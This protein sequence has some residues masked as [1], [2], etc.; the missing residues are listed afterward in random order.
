MTFEDTGKK[1]DEINVDISYRII[2][3]FSKGLYA[4][5][6]KA[7]E[8]L[9]S[10]SYDAFADKVAVYVPSDKA[11]PD[12]VMWVCDNGEALNLNGLK[13]LWRIGESNKRAIDYTDK[14][15]VPIGKFGIGKL[16]TYVLSRKLTHI[17]KKDGKYLAVTMDYGR[18]KLV[19]QNEQLILDA[20]EL[21]EEEA[22]GVL[23]QLT[24]VQGV[25]L[26]NF[27]LF[28]KDAEESWTFALMSDLTPKAN[29]LKNGRLEWVLSTAL[30]LSPA[31]N[32]FFNGHTIDSS[33]LKNKPIKTWIIGRDDQMITKFKEYEAGSDAEKPC[34]NLPNLNGVTGSIELYEESLLKG[35]SEDISRSNG[36]FLMIRGRLVNLDDP[37]LG[38]PA[39]SHGVF[40]RSR[41]VVHADGLDDYLS[42]TRESIQESKA[43]SDLRQYIQRKFEEV[44]AFYFERLEDKDRTQN[45][46]YKVSQTSTTMSRRPLLVVARKFFDEEISTPYLI[47]I[48]N[49]LTKPDQDNLI[50]KLEEELTNENGII[51]TV[52]LEVM[53]IDAPIAKL[54]LNSG[55]VKI[56]ILHPFFANFIE[57]FPNP[58][59]FQLIAITEILTEA[60][61]LENGISQ[62]KVTTIMQSR[63]RIFR[64][65]TFSDR[66]RAPI[67]AHKIQAAITDP[68]GLED[69]VYHAFNSL[70]FET[71][72]IGGSGKPD[73][74]AVA[75]VGIG[76]SLG[77]KKEYSVLYDAKS[78]SKEKVKTKDLNMAGI[79][80]HRTDYTAD[81]SVIIALD[82]EG[83]L[84]PTSAA[85]KEAKVQNICLIR[86][87]DLIT[88]VLLA[89]PKRLGFLDFKDL[90]ENNHTVAETSAW[91]ENLKQRQVTMGPIKELLEETF[92]IMQTDKEPP[93]LSAL[94]YA[95]ATLKA[96]SKEELRSLV[97]SLNRLVG[98]LISLDG[99]KVSMQASP[100]RILEV[101]FKTVNNDIPVDYNGVYI[102]AFGNLKPPEQ[103]K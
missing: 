2:E 43:L 37:L 47:D 21:T 94:R 39:L 13:D 64:Q 5:P 101:L 98:N 87:S 41:I 99:D 103:E 69:A 57:E 60:L 97:Q 15:R 32:L 73:G 8:E 38:M 27:D 36:I 92:K 53:D 48:P 44:K 77:T 68:S 59:P 33:K 70:G 50:L 26:L 71:T 95:N 35:K 25:N 78:T 81:Y 52:S 3:L 31:F 18:I 1:V 19:K 56:N 54:D 7:F 55:K 89:S 49:N 42:S 45:V 86:A 9:V 96:C 61:M 100:R 10:N 88:L 16:A 20:R 34:I 51:K 66:P 79:V 40:N 74:K 75:C 83:A 46:P 11:T 65:L 67:V 85:S 84:D 90:F 24:N 93:D 82:F 4:S 12:A 28:G 72:K 23:V 6:N 76:S 58:V 14:D 91:I 17:S 63:D 80:R 102:T 22:R 62:D 29:E 30:P